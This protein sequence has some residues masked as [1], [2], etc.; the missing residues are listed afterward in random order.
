MNEN[1]ITSFDAANSQTFG[2]IL[3]VK[4]AKHPIKVGLLGC[5]YFEYWRMYPSLKKKVEDDLQKVYKRLCKDFEV[6]YPCMV[7]TLDKAE[8]AGNAFSD[9]NVEVIIVVEGTY[10]PDFITLHAIEYVSN[11]SI[12]LFNTQTGSNVSPDDDYEATMRNS[13]FIGISQLTG[14]FRKINRNYEVVVDELDNES[15]Y[16]KIRGLIRVHQI[17]RYLKSYAIGIIGHVFRGMYDLE[18]D[19]TKIKGF[20]GPEVITIQ[21]DHLIIIWKD[22]PDEE[23]EK[24]AE[25]L[26]NRFAVK[27]VTMDDARRSCRLG[28]AMKR[29][30]QRYHLDALCFL[31]QHY[32]EKM[33]GA[34]ARM[35]ASMLIEDD[36][37]MVTC[38]G[39]IGGLIM[40]QI[41]YEL[42]GNVPLQAEWG[43][44]DI[45]NNALFLLG[46]GIASPELAADR[47]LVTLTRSPEEWGFKGKG[48]NY[49]MIIK[50]GPVTM[51]HFLNT[52]NGWR[53][54]ISEG[55]SIPFSCLPCDEIHAMVQVA[56]PIKEYVTNV[57]KNGVAH[58]LI[59]VHGHIVD[60]LA[61]V[62]DCMGIDKIILK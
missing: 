51:G 13:A 53:M 58:H 54:F 40:M 48:I 20:L 38:E 29:L 19:R 45:K 16:L 49:Q 21:I 24:T 12:I 55:E 32:I 11:A 57:L 25:E 15:A 27:H 46:H 56:T 44:F 8:K 34:P 22:I 26:M 59:L 5:G 28:L 10:L 62:A 43:Q 2:D 17:T 35:G 37:F 3:N 18:Y 47:K 52:A 9:A 1:N 14:T 60:E 33:T 4:K 41:M 36:R 7:D 50:P 30:A 31:G 6:V 61:S 42:T 39:D 23:V